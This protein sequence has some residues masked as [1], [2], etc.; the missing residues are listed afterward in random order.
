[1]RN[2]VTILLI[3]AAATVLTARPALAAETPEALEAKMP[4]VEPNV[5][6]AKIWWTEMPNKWTVVGWKDHILRFN[7]VHNGA[8]I[9]MAGWMDRMRKPWPDPNCVFYFRPAVR[10]ED[11]TAPPEGANPYTDDG[12]VI[13][14]WN[15]SEAPVLWS[16]WQ[17]F[18]ELLRQEVFAH[19]P[20]GK[21]LKRGDEPLFAWVRLS[22]PYI[23]EGVPTNE[24]TG[25]GIQINNPSINVDMKKAWTLRYLPEGRKYGRELTAEAETYNSAKGFHVLEG[26]GRVR[27]AVAPGQDCQVSF[28]KGFPGDKDYLLHVGWLNKVG[29]H[30]DLLI[31]MMPVDRETFDK[32]L[33]L[34]YDAALKE[35][36]A[37]W[38]VKPETAATFDVPEDYLNQL[39]LRNG[40][41]SEVCAERDPETGDYTMLT[42]GMG[43]GVGTWVT[44]TAIT[45]GM[46]YLPLGRF[47]V[48]EKYL[49]GVKQAQGTVAPPGPA[50]KLHPGYLSLPARVSVVHWLC[51]HGAMLWLISEHVRLSGNPKYAEEWMPVIEKAC[52]WI[53]YARHLEHS[54]APGIMP[55]AGWS[56]DESRVQSVWSD[57]WIYQGLTAAIEL[58]KARNHP[59][60][61]EFEKEAQ[62][63][64]AA[65]EKA[66]RAKREKM[67]TWTGPDGKVRKMVPTF[68]GQEQPWQMKHVFYLDAGPL[69]L[70]AS[71]LLD[72]NDPA[73][74]DLL[75]WFREGP[76]QKMARLE[77]DYN[78]MPFLY[79]EV[80]S[81]EICYSWNIFH[82]WRVADRQRFL[83][84]M[85]AMATGGYSQQTYSVCEERGGM[86]AATNWI[87]TVQ[88][89]RNSVIDDHITPGELHL[90]RLCPL[91]WLKT[92]RESR[93]LNMPT[94]Y[95][96]VNLAAKLGSGGRSLEISYSARFRQ[97]PTTVWLHIPPV[98][99]LTTVTVNGKP[100]QW[101]GRA[102]RIRLA[103]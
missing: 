103:E 102:K 59:R 12:A 15:P 86:L 55:P 91:A 68:I 74:S 62:E 36:E 31:P 32:E 89:L 60:A 7:V 44:P 75:L 29:S 98:Q 100:A 51:D 48:V 30:V 41:T 42:G 53:K 16:E 78:H 2:R 8:I 34:G 50:F 21:A 54:G 57:S 61:A 20:G 67:Q 28:R 92:D 81:W 82:S 10:P 49:Q 97:E 85:Y 18:G 3:I 52:D 38:K 6:V 25:F 64:K 23:A 73:I 56:D 58:M 45:M 27:L 77:L 40:Q 43:Y 88:H 17:Y 101:D 47:D 76:P 37:Y 83:E 84:G 4:V 63:Y 95:G 33:A 94:V 19:V 72:A 65:F 80:S 99:G 66:F 22:V 90:L 46:T 1:M 87:P 5:E 26:D 11:A 71:G 35:A 93:F 24:R 14:G 70:V 9:T 13:Q 79:H 39:I 69:H 96:P